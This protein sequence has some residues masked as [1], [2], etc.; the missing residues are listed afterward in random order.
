MAR[1]LSGTRF[2]ILI[3]IVGLALA[4]AFFFVFGGLGLLVA[5]YEVLVASLTSGADAHA[6][7]LPVEVEIVEYVHRFLIGTVLYITAVGLY[8]LFIHPI[9]FPSWLRID[10]TE[11][12]ETNL[13]G[14]TVVVMAVNFM[15]VVF[16]Q[17]TDDLLRYGVGIALPIAAL[18]LYIG[19]RTWSTN[20]SK[21]TA[22]ETERQPEGKEAPPS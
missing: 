21:K 6:A 15:G 7:S 13:I 5:L 2:L 12:L 11:E 9:E 3:P 10:S 22:L 4:A 20:L 14:V 8:Q 1:F 17:A 16:T 18:S 19:L